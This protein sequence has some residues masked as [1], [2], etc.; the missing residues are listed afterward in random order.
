MELVTLG[1]YPMETTAKSSPPLPPPAVEL[2][3]VSPLMDLLPAAPSITPQP[4]SD[5]SLPSAPVYP[6]LCQ[7]NFCSRCGVIKQGSWF[8]CEKCNNKLVRILLITFQS[9]LI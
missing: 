9:D 3:S 1:D 6:P 8:D 4:F 5:L 7:F 2:P